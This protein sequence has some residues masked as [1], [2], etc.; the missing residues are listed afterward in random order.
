MAL[1]L[2]YCGCDIVVAYKSSSIH[3]HK[4]CSSQCLFA[5]AR[6]FC[7]ILDS[8]SVSS[9]HSSLPPDMFRS[10]SEYRQWSLLICLSSFSL[11]VTG[12][13]QLNLTHVWQKSNFLLPERLDSLAYYTFLLKCMLVSFLL[14]WNLDF[15][16]QYSSPGLWVWL[17]HYWPLTHTSV[18]LQRKA[19]RRNSTQKAIL[20]T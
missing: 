13:T 16:G 14:I 1:S 8:G 10:H 3:C 4:L 2:E 12:W 5:G 6:Q 19:L 11:W 18:T 15:L 9:S 17:F 20:L 7:L